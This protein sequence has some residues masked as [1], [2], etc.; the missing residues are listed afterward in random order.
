MATVMTAVAAFSALRRIGSSFT[1]N[2]ALSA[3][4]LRGLDGRPDLIE[5][6]RGGFYA[7]RPTFLDASRSVMTSVPQ[8]VTHERMESTGRW[9]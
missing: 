1:H 4:R 5:W 3:H 7:R 6:P 9:V 8:G 2:N